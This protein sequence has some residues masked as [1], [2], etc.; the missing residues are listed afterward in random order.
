VARHAWT[1]FL[2]G[3]S[4]KLT[5]EICDPEAVN[6]PPI[7]RLILAGSPTATDAFSIP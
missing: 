1:I 3:F 5:P 7:L 2:P 6:F 4:T